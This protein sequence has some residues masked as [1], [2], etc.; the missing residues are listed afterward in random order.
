MCQ[1]QQNKVI[2]TPP[3]TLTIKRGAGAASA[4]KVNTLPGFH[5]NSD[6]PKQ[7]YLIPLALTWTS[8]P[9]KIKSVTY[10]APEEI[11][12]GPD[13]LDVFTGTFDIKTDFSAPSAAP[14]GQTV[15]TG[16]LHYQACNNRMCFR[17]ATIDVKLPVVVE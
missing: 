17:P 6:K 16:K 4:L 7:D 13:T 14:A 12:L 5:V 11:Q 3:E 2:V 9:L 1:A 15:M 10:P 8:G